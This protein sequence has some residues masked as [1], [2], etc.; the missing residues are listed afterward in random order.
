MV[1]KLPFFL[2]HDKVHRIVAPGLPQKVYSLDCTLDQEGGKLLEPAL[3]VRRHASVRG[4]C[5]SKTCRRSWMRK[6]MTRPSSLVISAKACND[7]LLN[8]TSVLKGCR[9]GKHE[10]CHGIAKVASTR[11]CM[12]Y[13]GDPP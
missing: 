5:A 13:T 3:R 4:D 11:S 2:W 7:A 8:P 6:D 12:L 1:R 10:M 9:E